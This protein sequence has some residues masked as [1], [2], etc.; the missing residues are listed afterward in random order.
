MPT[1]IGSRLSS[2]EFR[3]QLENELNERGLNFSEP[4]DIGDNVWRVSIQQQGTKNPLTL[5]LRAGPMTPWGTSVEEA[6]PGGWARTFGPEVLHGAPDVQPEFRNP[7]QAF[8]SHVQSALDPSRNK[9]RNRPDIWYNESVTEGRMYNTGGGIQ[10]VGGVLMTGPEQTHYNATSIDYANRVRIGLGRDVYPEKAWDTMTKSIVTAGESSPFRFLGGH[11]PWSQEGGLGGG[12]LT[13]RS[14][15]LPIYS[16]E[17]GNYDISVLGLGKNASDIL[18]RLNVSRYGGMREQAKLVEAVGDRYIREAQA[19][20]IEEGQDWEQRAGYRES[21]IIMPGENRARN[22]VVTPGVAMVGATQFPGGFTRYQS[23][24]QGM[25]SAAYG[26]Q[27]EYELNAPNVRGLTK[28]QFEFGLFKKTAVKDK[29]GEFTYERQRELKGSYLEAG[30][31][32]IIGLAH[33]PGKG[34]KTT[35]QEMTFQ[36]EQETYFTGDPR[37]ITPTAFKKS[38]GEGVE[39][40]APIGVRS[41]NLIASWQQKQGIQFMDRPEV[42]GQRSPLEMINFPGAKSATGGETARVFVPY[43]TQTAME[44]K[45]FGVKL[46]AAISSDWKEIM[47]NQPT[48]GGVPIYGVTGDVK[49]ETMRFAGAFSSWTPG[50]QAKALGAIGGDVGRTMQNYLYKKYAQSTGT[51]NQ[52][53]VYA[54]DLG[55]MYARLTGRTRMNLGEQNVSGE[56]GF[57]S[58]IDDVRQAVYKNPK[59]GKELGEVSVSKSERPFLPVG[60]IPAT[61]RATYE[62]QAIEALMRPDKESGR[63]GLSEEAAREA[64]GG[65]LQFSAMDDPRKLMMSFRSP[66][67]MRVGTI[68]STI[69]P[70]HQGGAPLYGLEEAGAIATLGDDFARSIGM[71]ANQ[72]PADTGYMA[73]NVQ[74]WREIGQVFRYTTSPNAPTPTEARDLDEEQRT[75]L[76]SAL[77]GGEKD[78][79]K[80]SAIVGGGQGML[81]NPNTGMLIENPAT[82][83]HVGAMRYGDKGLGEN[84]DFMSKIYPEALMEWS[85]GG[86]YQEGA[87]EKMAYQRS[88]VFQAQGKRANQLMMAR[89]MPASFSGRYGFTTATGPNQILIQQAQMTRM[90]KGLAQQAG[91]PSSGMAARSWMAEAQSVI[92][93]RQG[94]PGLFNRFPTLA[95][96][97]GASIMEMV[98]PNMIFQQTGIRVPEGSRIG[99]G[100]KLQTGFVEASG[101]LGSI[102]PLRVQDVGDWDFDPAAIKAL[103][104]FDKSGKFTPNQFAINYLQKNKNSLKQYEAQSQQLVEM[105]GKNAQGL[106]V[107]ENALGEIASGKGP[108]EAGLTSVGME[109][110]IASGGGKGG[111]GGLE[112]GGGKGLSYNRRRG[113]MSAAAVLGIPNDILEAGHTAQAWGFQQYLDLKKEPGSGYTHMEEAMRT[114]TFGEKGG[115]LSMSY[116]EVKPSGKAGWIDA[117]M[118]GRSGF[119]KTLG[120]SLGEQAARDIEE[121][122]SLPEAEAFAFAQKGDDPRVLAESWKASKL[123]PAQE[124]R[125]YVQ[126]KN[127]EFTQS[128]QGV[129][130]AARLRTNLTGTAIKPG[131]EVPVT[132]GNQGGW[133]PLAEVGANMPIRWGNRGMSSML[134]KSWA[135]KSTIELG[136]VLTEMQKRIQL[137]TPQQGALMQAEINAMQSAGEDIPF[138]YQY[139]A[140]QINANQ[141]YAA[142]QAASG[143]EYNT[144]SPTIFEPETRTM[145]GGK[146]A[147]KARLKTWTPELNVP[148]NQAQKST[149]QPAMPKED[150]HTPQLNTARSRMEREINADDQA[151]WASLSANERSQSVQNQWT[152]FGPQQEGMAEGVLMYGKPSGMR[153]SVW[154]EIMTLPDDVQ[155]LAQLEMFKKIEQGERRKATQVEDIE[156]DPGAGF[157]GG[158]VPPE[159]TRARNVPIDAEYATLQHDLGGTLEIKGTRAGPVA[160]RTQTRQR[161][162]AV[163]RGRGRRGPIIPTRT[164]GTRQSGQQEY[165]PWIYGE[166]GE[167]L[168]FGVE[169]NLGTPLSGWFGGGGGMGGLEGVTPEMIEA[170]EAAGQEVGGLRQA[171]EHAEKYGW[172]M[173]LGH[174][175]TGSAASK[176]VQ[177]DTGVISSG[178]VRGQER[179]TKAG[180]EFMGEVAN[181]LGLDPDIVKN[182]PRDYSR[183]IGEAMGQYPEQMA[184]LMQTP[185]GRTMQA[186]Q[187]EHAK[188]IAASK[189]VSGMPIKPLEMDEMMMS[190]L[191]SGVQGSSELAKSL[192]IASAATGAAKAMGILKKDYYE[193]SEAENKNISESLN[194]FSESLKKADENVK[195]YGQTHEET[196]QSILKSR[197]AALEVDRS[198]RAPQIAGLSRDIGYYQSTT[199]QKPWSSAEQI[200]LQKKLSTL[201]DQE[202][203]ATG[204]ESAIAK[205][206]EE[207]KP[208]MRQVSQATRHLIGG[209]GLFYMGTLAKMGVGSFQEGYAEYQQSAQA[210]SQQAQAAFG[211]GQ[212][213]PY[214]SPEQLRTTALARS[215]GG[216]YQAMR[217]I[218]TGTIGAGSDIGGAALTGIGAMGLGLHVAGALSS[219]PSAAGWAGGIA[220]ASPLIGL[221]V[222][223]ASLVGVQAAYQMNREDTIAQAAASKSSGG[224]WNQLTSN[225]KMVGPTIA[226]M[227]KYPGANLSELT[228]MGDTAIG[229]RNRLSQMVSYVS[230]ASDYTTKKSWYNLAEPITVNY[231]GLSDSERKAGT[232]EEMA[233]LAQAISTTDIQGLEHLPGE[234]KSQLA[235]TGMRGGLS[236]Y[237]LRQYI[238]SVGTATQAGLPVEQLAQQTLA[239]QG[240]VA[241][242]ARQS[243]GLEKLYSN[244]PM[245]SYGMLQGWD[246]QQQ[247]Y[248]AGA[249]AR[250]NAGQQLMMKT[251]GILEQTYGKTATEI[252]QMAEQQ[253]FPIAGGPREEAFLTRANVRQQAIEAG[254]ANARPLSQSEM[255]RY[256]TTRGTM[257]SRE[258][259]EDMGTNLGETRVTA[260]TTD[261]NA[262]GVGY[263][264]ATE[265]AAMAATPAGN[266]LQQRG[267]AITQQALQ[268]GQ[269]A[270]VGG[271]MQW[272][273]QNAQNMGFYER[274][275]GGSPIAINEMAMQMQNAGNI[276]GAQKYSDMFAMDIGL[277]GRQTGMAWGT[278]SLLKGGHSSDEMANR[279]FGTTGEGSAAR[280]AA[281]TGI[282]LANGQV[283]AG[284]MGLRRYMEVEGYKQQETQ[285]GIQ[286][287][288]IALQEK[289]QPMFWNIEDRQRTLAD[290]QAQWGFQMQE[291][292]A[293]MQRS[294]FQEQSALQRT[295]MLTSRQWAREDWG[296]QD[297][298]RAMQWGWK[299]QDFQE[300]ARFM[301]GRD[302]RLAERGMERETI[303][304]GMQGDEIERQRTRQKQQ[305][306]WEDES[307]AQKQKHFNESQKLQ[308]EDR[309][310]QKEFYEEGK[311]LHDEQIVLQRAMWREQIELQKQAAAASK[312]YATNMKDASEIMSAI[313][314]AQQIQ[315][316]AS[317][318]ARENMATLWDNLMEGLD[319]VVAHVTSEAI[320]AAVLG[321]GTLGKPP[322]QNPGAGQNGRTNATSTAIGG[323]GGM[324]KFN[325]VGEAGSEL[326]R[327]AGAISVI[328]NNEL[329]AMMYE[330]R[331]QDVWSNS[332]TSQTSPLSSGGQP[333]TVVINIGNERLG[334]YVVKAI[335]QELEA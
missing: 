85:S 190:D 51:E 285:Q 221:G 2:T 47:K 97:G 14:A 286:L 204:Q 215:G 206:R 130:T 301:T 4:T 289:Y 65:I 93:E 201:Q 111:L 179:F 216:V 63:K 257:T 15:G 64:M 270:P 187:K 163:Q 68:A 331:S 102:S 27:Q 328:P 108:N 222:G 238:Q 162:G 166:N 278:T 180:G 115:E 152:R 308:E 300:Q 147:K 250:L 191:A 314:T 25:Y 228:A 52:G 39:Q 227:Q 90:I 266:I 165:V 254:V 334:K 116:R 303:M 193:P 33:I 178:Y 49:E 41:P 29:P 326:I 276:A 9:I 268:Y 101:I 325:I 89:Q 217:T 318:L 72:G 291:R 157:I 258:R 261:W 113:L 114:L 294:Q 123:G 28:A 55:R 153:A 160:R 87:M 84:L 95:R 164:G 312:E 214:V 209:F 24:V 255:Q 233:R 50:M 3:A 292:Q 71:A 103:G 78:L 224:F 252:N 119:S 48:A 151:Y 199:G 69:S 229:Q 12:E 131:K 19:R 11:V 86:T 181:I 225:W 137:A 59:L 129:A 213:S 288:Q 1:R 117:I 18:K 265:R 249:L 196:R 271:A 79:E 20:P 81:R 31:S 205:S 23:P 34:G 279:I 74:A 333:V 239:L 274:V 92:R 125:N 141:D 200:A 43:A 70:A 335:E 232:P 172:K 237:S 243:V 99:P 26:S 32:A 203:A 122:T 309:N 54:E 242:T 306:Q 161:A 46:E 109:E 277:N 248:S 145:V 284:E 100:G 138:D 234:V 7:L 73:P 202:L 134:L 35:I 140:S 269:A 167:N 40:V 223:V 6:L 133:A 283:V 127:Y 182:V 219:I 184:R 104:L 56:F 295:Q 329:R 98:T 149:V 142:V 259:F 82:M 263:N 236:G 287:A 80:L 146:E 91:L 197:E 282:A 132:V 185:T 105:F 256:Y 169:T 75:A 112:A 57:Y 177:W 298:Q 188:I 96:K 61:E 107:S 247:T 76:Q 297:T 183:R 135:K 42:E 158:E 316:G 171:F 267:Q 36:A 327:P 246:N 218:G 10:T 315:A 77:S 194:K 319:W 53:K 21:N 136:S 5:N 186:G 273:L 139:A 231:G 174:G 44:E 83:Q 280:A 322:G 94:L 323:P 120:M 275:M 126:S 293:T 332:F 330:T 156:T 260:A 281:T 110:L 307:F 22:L 192:G 60:S 299:Q 173:N 62:K 317:N 66:G 220:A 154:D 195:K 58:L 313:N 210:V 150:M 272:A 8:T 245:L 262:L 244:A 198:I 320:Q 302:R 176:N 106:N 143:T 30:Q 13:M 241:P 253:Y 16:G 324:G 148:P 251:P 128:P 311:R 290:T 144:T 175:G 124:L 38:T 88:R 170:L 235:L 121:G 304:Y 207:D 212:V 118:P 45:S 264:I 240:V 296:Y 208:G 155:R 168:G 17:P 226:D 321:G 310:R 211:P 67:E 230:G 305:W 37:L 189:A 159:V